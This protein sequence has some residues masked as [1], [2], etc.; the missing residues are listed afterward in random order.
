MTCRRLFALA[1]LI[2]TFATIVGCSHPEEPKTSGSTSPTA[3]A[4]KVQRRNG[5][6]ANNGL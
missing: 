1:L 2:A 5:A 4:D 3:N 6:V